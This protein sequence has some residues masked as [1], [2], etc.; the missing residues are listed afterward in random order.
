MCPWHLRQGIGMV[1]GVV[2]QPM[3]DLVPTGPRR[4][5]GDPGQKLEQEVVD[6]FLRLLDLIATPIEPAII[7]RIPIQKIISKGVSG[8]FTSL[9][10]S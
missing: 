8:M 5:A 4:A 1:G 6:Y 7:P 9:V 2:L 10:A 3:G